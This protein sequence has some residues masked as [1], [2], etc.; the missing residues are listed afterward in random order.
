VTVHGFRSTF[1]DWAGEES[2]HPS[3][4]CEAALSHQL[5]GGKTRG[6]Y[7]RGYLLNKRR[8]LMNDW[9]AYCCS[10]IGLKKAA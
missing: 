6:A 10:P 7:Q 2:P 4:I 3:D 8:A 5:P 9:A 1:R